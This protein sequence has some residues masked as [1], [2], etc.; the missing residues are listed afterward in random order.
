MA[1]VPP[2]TP[3]PPGAAEDKGENAPFEPWPQVLEKMAGADRLLYSYMK[4]SKAY[5]NGTHVLID[6]G[7]MFLT[8]MR[9]ND[10]ANERIKTAIAQVTGHR[11]GIGPY[12]AAEAKK[13]QNTAED[14]LREW[15]EK[16]VAVEYK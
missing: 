11:Y 3:V 4:G 12:K 9:E 5:T 1:F 14:T 6:G 7:D 15:E 8:F 2:E 13:T 10:T 16:G